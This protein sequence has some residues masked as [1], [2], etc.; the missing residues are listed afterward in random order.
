M[1]DEKDDKQDVW[2][3]FDLGGTKMLAVILDENLKPLG[4]KRR[5]TRGHEGADAGLERIEETI[6]K[7]FKDADVDPSRLRGIGIGCPGILDLKKGIINEAP[8]LGWTDAMVC[9]YLNKKYDVPVILLND[10]DAGLYGEYHFGAAKKSRSVL[11]IFPGTGIGGAFLYEGKI[12]QGDGRSCMEI[13]HIQVMPDGPLCGCGR[14]GCLEAVASRLAISAAIAQAAFRG[15]APYVRD[16]VGTDLSEIRSGMI[17][18]AVEKDKVVK[19]IVQ[20][21]AYQ[22]GIAAGSMIHL[23]S[24]DK[25]VLGGGLAEALPDLFKKG[26]KSGIEDWIMPSFKDSYEV[27]VAELGDD[28]AVLGAAAYARDTFHNRVKEEESDAS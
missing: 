19:Q 6:Q 25:I 28:S 2:V 26:V 7:A 17:S 27:K 21:A 18:E 20:D 5:K 24:P 13:G 11:G 14:R 4:R 9:S 23:L 8:N 16:Q 1:S 12:M 15:Q 22:I 10:V 3:G